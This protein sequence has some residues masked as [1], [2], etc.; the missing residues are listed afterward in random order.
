MLRRSETF[1]NWNR[2][3]VLRQSI[4]KH[5]IEWFKKIIVVAYVVTNLLIDNN[6]FIISINNNF[7]IVINVSKVFHNFIFSQ[8]EIFFK[9]DV[10]L[11]KIFYNC[12]QSMIFN[13]FTSKISNLFAVFT[14]NIVVTTTKIVFENNVII[15]RFNNEI[16]KIFNKLID[17]Y[18]NFWKN[19]E[20]VVLS[21][22]N[23]MKILL[24][25]DWEQKILD[26]I[27]MYFL[28]KKNRELVNE[29]FDKLHEFEKLN[30]TKK[31]TSFNYFVFCV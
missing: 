17:E 19:I 24:K 20:F 10:E 1:Q 14:S 15:H 13:F 16:V 29:T 25:F 22:K 4:K 7:S 28:N 27:K 30:W 6:F 12:Y 11:L 8:R 26:K 21:K 3:I 23:W 18:S 5:K 2:D 31:F 9:I